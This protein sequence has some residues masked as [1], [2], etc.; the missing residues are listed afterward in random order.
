METSQT[1]E[2][3]LVLLN[4]P[5]KEQVHK[6]PTPRREIYFVSAKVALVLIIA[7]TYHAF[8][9]YIAL[10]H[11]QHHIVPIGKSGALVTP[12]LQVHCKLYHF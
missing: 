11:D 9:F 2:V 7:I 6:L 3:E 1:E 12:F 5:E 10:N 8:C 4:K